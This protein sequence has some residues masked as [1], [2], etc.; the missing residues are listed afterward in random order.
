MDSLAY[1]RNSAGK[2]DVRF[3][4]EKRPYSEFSVFTGPLGE[5]FRVYGVYS[6]LPS[7]ERFHHDEARSVRF[8]RQRDGRLGVFEEVSE[9]F[10]PRM[11]IPKSRRQ[12][13]A[14]RQKGYET[15]VRKVVP[16]GRHSVERRDAYGPDPPDFR[17]P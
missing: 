5:F 13:V 7:P 12:G 9:Q 16:E 2:V 14:V 17:L 6:S 4:R 10:R 3:H 15:R 11:G 8:F 1:F